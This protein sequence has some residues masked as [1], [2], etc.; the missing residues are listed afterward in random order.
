MMFRRRQFALL[1][2]MT[3]IGEPMGNQMLA[4]AREALQQCAMS[5]L[6]A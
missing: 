4:A 5:C 3:D 1:R 6:C 2:L